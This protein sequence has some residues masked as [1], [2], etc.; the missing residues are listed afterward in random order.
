ME[1]CPNDALKLVDTKE[2][3]QEKVKKIVRDS[4]PGVAF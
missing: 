3:G 2:I 1:A 4:F